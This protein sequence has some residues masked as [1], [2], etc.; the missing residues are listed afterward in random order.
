MF[1]LN[2][3]YNHFLVNNSPT[4]LPSLTITL[5][6]TLLFPTFGPQDSV[7][8]LIYV[9]LIPS[10]N[11]ITNLQSKPVTGVMRRIKGVN[12]KRGYAMWNMHHSHPWPLLQQG[13]WVH[14]P[15][16]SL[17]IFQPDYQFAT[18]SAI[19]KYST[20]SV[21]VFPFLY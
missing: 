1:K 17:N 9:F 10:H 12:M 19:H 15:P 3:C 11:H 5:D 4:N 14:Q 6:L 16:P 8:I 21:A 2:Q 20:G 7:P 13:V 18:K